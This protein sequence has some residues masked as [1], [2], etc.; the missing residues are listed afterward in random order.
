MYVAHYTVNTS[1]HIATA[2]HLF[3][4]S[5]FKNELLTCLS[6]HVSTDVRHN[7]RYSHDENFSTVGL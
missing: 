7:G 6:R 4:T 3:S 1:M 5:S 2:Y